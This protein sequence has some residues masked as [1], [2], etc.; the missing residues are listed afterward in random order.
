MKTFSMICMTAMCGVLTLSSCSEEV[1]NQSVPEP[2]EGQS[3]LGVTTRG[4]VETLQ[5]RLYVFNDAGRCVLFLSPDDHAQLVTTNL[6]AGTYDLYG[7]GSDDLSNFVLP[8]VDDATA[9]TEL[10]V[11]EGKQMGDLLMGHETI[12]LADGDRENIDLQLE[13]KVSHVTSITIHEVP[14]DVEQV[15]VTVSPM[16]QKI[17]L[18]GTLSDPTGTYTVNLTDQ[19]S[20]DW[21][22]EP[23]ALILP[24]KNRPT[25]TITFN[26][27]ET[28]KSYSYAAVQSLKA[29]NNVSLEGTFVGLKGIVLTAIATPQSWEP[30]SRDI[31]F[32]FDE[33]PVAGQ[34]YQGY[35]VVT[36]DPTNRTATLLSL[37]S[38]SFTAPNSDDQADWLTAFNTAMN[39]LSKPAFA[40]ADDQWRLP[41]EE[42]IKIFAKNTDY[43]MSFDAASGYGSIYFYLTN[44]T[45]KWGGY[46]K[47]GNELLFQTNTNVTSAMSLRPVIDITY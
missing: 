25:I 4:D 20:G 31:S 37:S 27:G 7:I 14:S 3:Q 5:S 41:T 45:L 18:N 28:T 16:Y 43:V 11:A 6:S 9:T 8:T 30:D 33:Y 24:S 1:M 26:K 38:I 44:N 29:N 35:F 22:A 2:V 32:D 12:T 17:L 36:N 15:S 21:A 40:A 42:E 34:T 23:D 47:S 13:R 10:V 39:N 19:G 46:R